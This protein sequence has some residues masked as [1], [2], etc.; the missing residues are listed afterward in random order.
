MRN[1]LRFTALFL[2]SVLS[3][4]LAINAAGQTAPSEPSPFSDQTNPG[5]AKASP[6]ALGS[7]PAANS[8]ASGRILMF[9]LNAATSRE[10]FTTRRQVIAPRAGTRG[11][12]TPVQIARRETT[13]TTPAAFRIAL[14]ETFLAS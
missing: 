6:I 11:V 13:A 4:C 3:A 5:Y 7:T 10:I 1:P 12:R 2:G 9:P 14:A 8:A